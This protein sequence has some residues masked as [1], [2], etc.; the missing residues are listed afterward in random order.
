MQLGD[1]R[2]FLWLPLSK[3]LPGMSAIRRAW[4]AARIAAWGVLASLW[5][6]LPVPTLKGLRRL[7]AR[8]SAPWGALPVDL[9]YVKWGVLAG[10]KKDR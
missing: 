10:Q 6:L 3:L 5:S 4:L 8:A 2:F 9:A 7:A 1:P